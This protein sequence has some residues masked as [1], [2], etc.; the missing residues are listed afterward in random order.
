MREGKEFT[1]LSPIQC[2]R[3]RM[4][5]SM[6]GFGRGTV[7]ER[8]GLSGL[9]QEERTKRESEELRASSYIPKYDTKG[10]GTVV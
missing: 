2:L 9:F 7:R 8:E 1:L 3:P 10:C 4:W 6:A 5:P